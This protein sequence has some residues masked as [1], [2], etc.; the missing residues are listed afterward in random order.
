MDEVLRR[1]DVAER[2]TSRLKEEV[3]G[4]L[5]RTAEGRLSGGE[6]I[7]APDPLQ[8]FKPMLV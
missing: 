6:P 1:P 7:S 4:P 2:L 8:T 3:S 5:G